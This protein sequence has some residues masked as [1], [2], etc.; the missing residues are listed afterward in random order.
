M[1]RS[2]RYTLTS[3]VIILAWL[4]SQALYAK[5]C[6]VVQA[7]VQSSTPERDF[8][9]HA[10]GTLTHLRSGL[11]WMRCSLGQRWRKGECVGES[12]PYDWKAANEAVAAFNRGE[13]AKYGNWRLPVKE[14]LE[15]LIEQRCRYPAI[16]T[17]LFPNTA[18]SPYWSSTPYETY[19]NLAWYVDFTQGESRHYF[20]HMAFPLRLVRVP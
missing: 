11:M 18:A 10:D 7:S 17:S 16:N 14:E 8:L 2:I 9:V 4:G 1:G 5:D 6:G 19:T 3:G 12:T 13:G 20:T 15:S